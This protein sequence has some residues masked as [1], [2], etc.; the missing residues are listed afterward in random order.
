MMAVRAWGSAVVRQCLSAPFLW[1]V[2]SARAIALPG[3]NTR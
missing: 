1:A 3:R 2:P